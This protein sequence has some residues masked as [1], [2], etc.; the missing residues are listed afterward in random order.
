MIFGV[1]H[2][3][4]DYIKSVAELFS[5]VAA[6]MQCTSDI[7]QNYAF[8]SA[9][10]TC[11]SSVGAF[12]DSELSVVVAG[13]I[14]SNHP[15]VANVTSGGNEKSPAVV[16]AKL[17]KELRSSAVG[18]TSGQ[19][20]AAV[21]DKQQ[22]TL[23][24]FLDRSGGIKA[25]YYMQIPDGFA[26]CSSLTT[27]LSMV[28][29]ER[30]IEVDAVWDLF[31]TGYVVPP[32]TVIKHVFKVLPG[33]EVVYQEG[34]VRKKIA[35][36]IQFNSSSQNPGS[37]AQLEEKLLA[38]LINYNFE[39]EAGFLLSGG[40]DSSM[41]VALT[42]RHIKKPITTFTASFP[43]S[44]LDEST[45]AKI[46]ANKYDCRY[47]EIDLSQSSALDDLPEIVW[48][49]GE[50]F[51][52]FSVIPTFQ[53]FKRL[54]QKTS[55]LVSGDGPDHL[56][57]RFYPL[58]AKRY[59]DK[60]Y[61]FIIKA[62]SLFPFTFP[63]KIM[64]AGSVSLAEA[65]RGLFALPA[66]G[67]AAYNSLY[68]L[69]N[70]PVPQQN[71]LEQYAATLNLPKESSLEGYMDA[72]ATMDFY[73]DGAFGVFG[74]IGRMADA[75]GLFVREPYLDR[76]VSDYIAQLPLPQKQGGTLLHL[77]ASRSQEKRL[78]KFG[79]GPRYLPQEIINKKKGGFTPPLGGWLR[80]SIC[81]LPASEL[82]CTTLKE[83]GFLSETV[84]DMILQ[85]H[86]HGQRDW[87][88]IIFMIISFDLWLRMFIEKEYSAFPG[89]TFKDVYAV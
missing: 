58:A 71:S 8:C 26:F 17:Y 67:E 77:L 16:F 35:D 43:G 14:S 49:L 72:L 51:L 73:L 1:V 70:T 2:E 78:L 3:D 69:V 50:P 46:V 13:E 20:C 32:R 21:W 89:W 37:T 38:C 87:S 88:R 44:S 75:H 9:S 41:L 27:L 59:V 52:D 84:L 63:K 80:K 15:Q 19:F 48:H 61:K 82:L 53:L 36:L 86:K 34:V 81:S 28:K 29:I 74:K 45:Y 42:S 68:G 7:G 54:S 31:A 22:Y 10:K 85:E 76:N 4:A 30:Q 64:R 25:L 65:Y 66:W 18:A 40:I 47:E 39:P 11:V 23:S 6:P 12:S 5:S 60:N 24:L 83:S 57:G 62:M 33:Q 79:I 55:L 56:F